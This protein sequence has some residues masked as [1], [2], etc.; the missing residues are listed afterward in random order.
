MKNNDAIKLSYSAP[1]LSH[2]FPRGLHGHGF[3]CVFRAIG[4]KLHGNRYNYADD[5]QSVSALL[6]LKLKC[7]AALCAI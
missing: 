4:F 1:L 2:Q 3:A 6:W 7:A 5:V